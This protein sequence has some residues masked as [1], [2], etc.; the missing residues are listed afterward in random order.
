MGNTRDT[1]YLRN[2]VVYDGSGNITLPANLAVTS[3][4]A[5]NNTTPHDTSQFSLDING[6]L[7]VK[8][9][10]KTAQFVIINS[11]PATGGNHAFVQHTVGGTSGS[12]YVDIQ[13][14][15]GLAVTGSTVIRLN[16]LGGNVLIGSLIGT[17][18]R[19]VV[20]DATGVL[21]TQATQTLGNLG[22]VP[23]SRTLTINGTAYDLSADRSWTI[24]SMIYPTAGISVS[25]GSAWGTSLTDNSANWNTAFGWGNHA[26][27]T[28]A[29]QTYVGT[30]IANLVASAPATLDTLNE[31]AAAL[32][33]D[34]AFS[35]TI[36]T[37]LGNRLRVDINTQ[38]LSATLQG[39][40]R[41]NLGL[42]TAAVSATGDFAAASHTHSIANVT[43]L[44][45]ALD[46]KVALTALSFAAGSGAYN[47]T[48]GVI[49]IPTNNNQL[50]N[51]AGYITGTIPT[52]N[53]Q[54]TNGAGYITSSGSISGNA[55]TAT[56]LSSG[57]TN[58][59]GTG[60]LGNVVGMLAWKNYSN[61]HVIFDA[62]AGTSPSGTAVN[63]TNSNTA[64]TAAYPTLMGW[65]GAGTYGVRVDS[66]RISDSTSSVAWTN[67]SGRPTA[68]SSF[69]NDSAYLAS[70]G[71]GNMTD[72][73]RLFNNMGNAHGTLTDFNSVGNFGV[74]YI[75]GSTNGPQS[76]QFYGFTLGLGNDYGYG[77]YGSQFYWMR[78][79][80]TPY[81]WI[82]YQE[83]GSQGSWNKIS[84]GYADTAGNITAYTI[85]QS[86]G[87][88]NAPTFDK[89]RRGSHS[90]GFLEGS[91]N[92][93]G[94][95]S[96]NSNPIYTI[97]S[98]YN[99]SDSSLGNMYGLGHAHPNFWG[100]GKTSGWGI[101]VCSGGT[102]NATIGEGATT[103]WA[104]NDIVAF[105]DARVKDNIEVVTNAIEKIQAIRGVT[106]TRKDA[107]V[108]DKDKRHAGVIAQEVL[109]VMPEVVTGT[110]EDMYSVAYG[111]MAALFI[112]AIKEQQLQIEE[113]KTLIHGITK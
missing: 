10:G 54:L 89:I 33:N 71:L 28:Y 52:N 3:N 30:Q 14:Y 27:A 29:T 91:Y 108:E 92:S 88:G 15:Y 46:G 67:V 93:V 44:Q 22:G 38:G 111:N 99:P 103:I 63:Q 4:V 112:E 42:G 32:G 83:A 109:K 26:S 50:T 23:T 70:V 82:R 104:Q 35:T 107:K 13:G 8:N 7:I 48:T 74:R 60:V 51:G 97:G 59:V 96:A 19:M 21:S 94:G 81:I 105:S 113:L 110:E 90:T 56:A 66:A 34:A 57:Q 49:T 73:H 79:T 37:A 95:N 55:A 101:Y 43:G 85:N 47:S 40:G 6:G 17:G 9:T 31:L 12:S 45:T 58:W 64:W 1:G 62:S 36:S 65:N 18:T 72:V 24:T 78:N 77:T 76:G 25:T 87:T 16:A 80:S 102:F 69:T 75:Q 5:I 61:S 53:N 100:G 20:A 2:L 39:Y 98:S 41:T 84:A 11:N 68:V 106:F 86:V